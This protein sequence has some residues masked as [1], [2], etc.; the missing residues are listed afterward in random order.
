VLLSLSTGAS[1]K[2]F[3]RAVALTAL[4]TVV[5]AGTARGQD[6]PTGDSV[7]ARIYEE[8]MHRSH[9][10]DLAQ[11]L[12]DS[13]GPRLT[14]SS[15][16]RAANA[17]LVRTYTAWGIP[18]RNEQYGTWR[19]WTRGPSR[20]M[21]VAPRTRVLEATALAWS[22]NTPAAG[23]DG[24]V[25][26]LPP[27]S[28]VR[29]KAA[30]ARW[31]SGV[32]GRFVMVTRPEGSCRPDT[33]WAA[34]ASAESYGAMRAARDS[35]REEWDR[36]LAVAGGSEAAAAAR[37][38]AAGALG[39][40]TSNWTG[41]WGVDKV[42]STVSATVPAF[43]V[44]CEDYALLA[45]LAAH[46]QHPRINALATSQVA[47]GEAPVFNTIAEV[48]GSLHPD[49]YVMLSA[50][51][52]S[53]DAGSGATD[54]GTGTIVM[55]EAMRILRLAYPHPKRTI[56]AGHW[57]GEEQGDIGSTAFAT[58]HP[59][60]L[61]GLEVLFNQDNGTGAVDSIDTNGFLDAPAAFARWMARMPADVTSGIT[62]DEPGYAKDEDSDSDA[63][64]CRGAPGFFLTSADY[65]YTDY[66]WHTPRD[67]YDKID[68]ADVRRNATLIAMLAY[69]A[70]EDST[71]LARARRIPPTD[72][73]TK[74]AIDPPAC[75]PAPRSWAKAASATN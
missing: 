42:M 29:D 50:H 74:R 66:T 44:S 19:D 36:R 71:R 59:E 6:L 63:F 1:V 48:R 58:D 31:L 70:S 37:V 61:R 17:W 8:G 20:V 52:D 41:G 67:T 68:F 51:L 2:A 26:L 47:D 32:R 49:E 10:A 64:A 7:V 3:V 56:L 46:G 60:V 34:W 43:D 40:L 14:G 28:D 75:A 57:S 18:A 55:L 73:K 72:R 5:R 27:V 23:S 65:G 69:E 4:A 33:S 24:D 15:A 53:W 9:A 25:V 45:R 22:V 35:A 39:V 30:F 21:L 11:V 12:A 62:I 16:N 38:A 54:N 13:I